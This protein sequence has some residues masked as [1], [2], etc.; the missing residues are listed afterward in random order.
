MQV[1]IYHGTL[2]LQLD[3]A[4]FSTWL[5]TKFVPKS[6]SVNSHLRIALNS[7]L[8]AKSL[9]VSGLPREARLV[10]VVRGKAEEA[11]GGGVSDLGWAS[12]QIFDSDL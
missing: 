6:E 9:P 8:E 12:L 11:L 3:S 7:W 1:C 4:N 2:P 5:G 10:F